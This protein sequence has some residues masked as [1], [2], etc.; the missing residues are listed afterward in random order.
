[1][2]N[3]LGIPTPRQRPKVCTNHVHISGH[4]I[5]FSVLFHGLD[6]VKP[7]AKKLQ[8]RNQDIYAAY[9]LIDEVADQVESLRKNVD[10]E[11]TDWYEMAKEMAEKVGVGPSMPRLAPCWS[12]FRNNVENDGPF[13]YYK[14]DVAIPVMEA[15][16]SHLVAQMKD[17]NHVELFALL[18]SIL[19]CNDDIDTSSLAS[20]LYKQFGDELDGI[21]GVAFTHELKRWKRNC[22]QI[23]QDKVSIT[24]QQPAIPT[25]T[26]KRRKNAQKDHERVD[27]GIHNYL[28]SRWFHRNPQFCRSWFLPKRAEAF[29]HRCYIAS[30]IVRGWKG[31]IRRSPLENTIP[32]HNEGRSRRKPEFNSTPEDYSRNWSWQ[33]YWDILRYTHID[34]M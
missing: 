9:H 25:R 17:R 33:S 20:K 29:G 30:R 14:R 6:P 11:F 13:T 7:L 18:P 2:K 3:G 27:G 31:S 24:Q 1:M 19:V 34:C 16:H 21:S 23:F 5:A 15:L 32:Y 8:K 4:L 12:R 28:S 26:D 10:A 22:E